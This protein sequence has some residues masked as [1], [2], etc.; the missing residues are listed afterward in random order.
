MA[1]SH[2]NKGSSSQSA[3][4]WSFTEKE[5]Y[6]DHVESETNYTSLNE[7]SNTVFQAEEPEHFNL[8][9]RVNWM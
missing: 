4:I 6:T 8:L 3:S 1:L 5:R 2:T 7:L 9:L